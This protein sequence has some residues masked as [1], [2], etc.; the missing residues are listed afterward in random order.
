MSKQSHRFSC[1]LTLKGLHSKVSW[2]ANR[3]STALVTWKTFRCVFFLHPY[4]YIRIENRAKNKRQ[5][6]IIGVS[7]IFYEVKEQLT[8]CRLLCC[9]AVVW[10]YVCVHVFCECKEHQFRFIHKW[11]ENFERIIQRSI[12][13]GCTSDPCSM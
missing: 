11:C 1:H 7:N 3:F 2:P 6:Q 12:L 5:R 8:L 13:M 10:V 4:V 9:H